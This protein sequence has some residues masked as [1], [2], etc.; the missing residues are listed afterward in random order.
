MVCDICNF[1]CCHT[2]CDTPKLDFVPEDDWLCLFCRSQTTNASEEEA[3]QS[4]EENNHRV[5][6]RPRPPPAFYQGT[7]TR[8]LEQ[9]WQRMLARENNGEDQR[10][11][12]RHRTADHEETMHPILFGHRVQERI[13]KEEM[14]ED[15]H[16]IETRIS[17]RHRTPSELY[18]EGINRRGRGRG[19]NR[20]EE[21]YMRNRI[22]LRGWTEKN[23][24][25]LMGIN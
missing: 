24:E 23:R 16:E 14:E 20:L 11:L 21:G 6:R 12:R 13:N 15:E 7:M 3:K 2:Y 5:L 22:G 4:Q 25:R 8:A 19:G 9:R 17:R 18:Q 1:F 10:I